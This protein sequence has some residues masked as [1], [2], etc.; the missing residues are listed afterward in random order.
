[1]NERLSESLR[2]Y[3]NNIV[4]NLNKNNYSQEKIAEV[5]NRVSNC[6]LD[7]ILKIKGYKYI[8]KYLLDGCKVHYYRLDEF[9]ACAIER[10]ENNYDVAFTFI[11]PKD[12]DCLDQDWK[13]YILCNY[14]KNKYTYKNINCTSP[15]NAICVAY[16]KN[17]KDFPKFYRHYKYTPQ[18]VQLGLKNT[19][20]AV[21]T[22]VV[23]KLTR[24]D[25]LINS[26]KKYQIAKQNLIES[27][28]DLQDVRYYLEFP[29]MNIMV[30]KKNDKFI[31]T[32]SFIT[33]RDRACLAQYC[34]ND[35]DCLNISKTSLIENYLAGKYTYVSDDTNN[36]L[37]SAVRQYNLHKAMFPSQYRRTKLKIEIHF[38]PN[39]SWKKEIFNLKTAKTSLFEPF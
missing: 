10:G 9:N 6:D 15:I 8:N 35:G 36:S 1:M 21:N 34:R 30:I 39:T 19:D 38:V 2:Q 25:H 23:D 20:D 17:M 24:P 5:V 12:F 14:L 26:G 4:E 27:G 3:V 29:T 16:N 13:K 7:V 28:V 33:S 18:I 31:V 11:N 37:S 22:M 32:F